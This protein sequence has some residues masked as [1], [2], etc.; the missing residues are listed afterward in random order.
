MIINS[1]IVPQDKSFHLYLVCGVL[2]FIEDHKKATVSKLENDIQEIQQCLVLS[3]G[4]KEDWIEEQ[5]ELIS[6]K[7]LLEELDQKLK[8]IHDQDQKIRNIRDKV[9]TYQNRRLIPK[10][11]LTDQQHFV[12]E[13]SEYQEDDE[14]LLAEEDSDSSENED[15]SE[16]ERE[17]PLQIFFCSRTHSQLSQLVGEVKSTTYNVTSV[18]LASRQSYCINS[19]VNKLRNGNQINEQCLELQKSQSK[20]T[21]KDSDGNVVKSKKLTKACPFYK[22]NLE[23]LRNMSISKVMDIEELV[24]VAKTEKSCPY[25]RYA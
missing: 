21:K 19:S 25:Y 3:I 18:S 5:Y 16:N 10:E 22:K 12:D 15:T 7:K 4:K 13:S 23:K 17:V 9:E 8:S 2:K 14:F 1:C 20:D 11:T 6:Q 24:K